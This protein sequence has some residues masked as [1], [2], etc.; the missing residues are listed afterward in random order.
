MLIATGL[1]KLFFRQGMRA[2]FSR[3]PSHW[4]TDRLSDFLNEMI[5]CLHLWSRNLVLSG[6]VLLVGVLVLVVV[7][8]LWL[9]P[10]TAKWQTG[11]WLE[12]ESNQQ[13]AKEACYDTAT[14]DRV[15]WR[16]ARMLNR[17][18]GD[19]RPDFTGAG[20]ERLQ[21]GIYLAAMDSVT[22]KAWEWESHWDGTTGETAEPVGGELTPHRL[23]YPVNLDG[24]PF[25]VEFELDDGNG[26]LWLVVA[27]GTATFYCTIEVRASLGSIEWE[28]AHQPLIGD[29]ADLWLTVERMDIVRV[30]Q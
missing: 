12:T 16:A 7:G 8:S 22:A 3:L 20:Y 30:G 6:F 1:L 24:L 25:A 19:V 11:R 15:S 28:I 14:R 26:G 29:I 27:S 18:L 10:L 2:L 13:A 17:Q 5:Q 21:N 23:G 4:L 9:M